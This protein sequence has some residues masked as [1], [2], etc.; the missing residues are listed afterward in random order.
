M[1]YILGKKESNNEIKL[2]TKYKLTQK[3]ITTLLLSFFSGLLIY[4]DLGGYFTKFIV[5]EIPRGTILGVSFL[6]LLLIPLYIRK[7]R[8]SFLLVA[9]VAVFVAV[10][11]RGES[12]GP[13]I[14]IMNYFLAFF[15][16]LSYRD[17]K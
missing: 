6:Y 10:F 1:L 16:I 15:S 17:A 11:Y 7:V 9:F 4:F 14:P 3:N 8:E 13:L 2:F 5:W 12:F